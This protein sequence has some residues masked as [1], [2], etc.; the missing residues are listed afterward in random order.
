MSPRW[1][2]KAGRPARMRRASAAAW[3]LPS[4]VSPTAAKVKGS[5]PAGAETAPR[6]MARVEERAWG[7]G[8]SCERRAAAGEAGAA[9]LRSLGS[10]RARGRASS[11]VVRSRSGRSAAPASPAAAQRG[12]WEPGRTRAVR[13]DPRQGL[14]SLSSPRS[15]DAGSLAPELEDDERPQLAAIVA[16][17]GHRLVPERAH[18]LRPDDPRIEALE[19]CAFAGAERIG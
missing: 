8:G 10:G 4:P 16:A 11:P 18:R 6:P 9:K 13:P 2:R 3:R 5:S 17:A 12:P 7:A 14:G 1:T 19:R 15:P